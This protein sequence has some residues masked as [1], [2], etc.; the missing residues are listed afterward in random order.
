MEGG[1]KVN[2]CYFRGT[3]VSFRKCHPVNTI[4]LSLSHSL[5]YT[6]VGRGGKVYTQLPPFERKM[7]QKE[8]K[9]DGIRKVG[10]ERKE[11]KKKKGVI[12]KTRVSVFCGY[13]D[14]SKQKMEGKSLTSRT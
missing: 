6:G 1:K 7:A 14:K 3:F 2:P 4:A 10:R 8:K 12:R 13:G 5:T 11:E 9:W